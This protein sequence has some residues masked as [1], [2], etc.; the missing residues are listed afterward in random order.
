MTSQWGNGRKVDIRLERRAT[1]P[2][3]EKRKTVPQELHDECPHW[4]SSFNSNHPVF[5]WRAWRILINTPVRLRQVLSPSSHLS[6]DL[7]FPVLSIPSWLTNLSDGL[8]SFLIYLTS[9]GLCVLQPSCLIR[10]PFAVPRLGSEQRGVSA[11][12][13]THVL[14]KI[15][16]TIRI[17]MCNK[18]K[19]LIALEGK[20]LW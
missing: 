6:C 8:P 7:A 10:T 19:L 1:R 9:F 5:I 16:K 17:L 4:V 2:Q 20:G 12:A 18:I 14:E 13:C 3:K 15:L 11:H